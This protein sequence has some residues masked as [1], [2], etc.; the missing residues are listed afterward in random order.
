MHY[1]HIH[2]LMYITLYN[3]YRS[4]L[5]IRNFIHI[6]LCLTLTIAQIAF[7]VGVNRTG[8]PDYPV[9]IHCQIIA[10]FL[11][12]FF[13]VSFMWMLMEGMVLYLALVK[14]FVSRTKGYL[15]GL[16]LVCYGLPVVYM[17]TIT[18]PLGF[19]LND[20]NHYGYRTA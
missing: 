10:V 17:G 5:I 7:V 15:I 16:S 9:P 20:K 6:N 12:Y 4:L 8:N 1:I 18:L 13:L 11:H 2:A 3:Y 14:V 19:A